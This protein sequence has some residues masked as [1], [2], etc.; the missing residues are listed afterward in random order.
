[1][2]CHTV[3]QSQEHS[4]L[5]IRGNASLPQ[6]EQLHEILLGRRDRNLRRCSVDGLPNLWAEREDPLDN[7]EAGIN[8]TLLTVVGSLQMSL[9][10]AD[11]VIFD[12]I[13]E[14]DLGSL[15]GFPAGL[16]LGPLCHVGLR[17]IRISKVLLREPST[18]DETFERRTARTV[19]GL[20][21]GLSRTR[22]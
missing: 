15:E 8:H 21:A 13:I 3:K 16:L 9:R 18:L 19:R 2:V 11:Q 6:A 7:L 4:S 14:P 10:C 20:E 22:C 5:P 17:A 1:M 12:S